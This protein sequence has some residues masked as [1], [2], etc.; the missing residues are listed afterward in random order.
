M[1]P[2]AY[3]GRD[4]TEVCSRFWVDGCRRAPARFGRVVGGKM[5]RT[6][7]R[8][9]T[10]TPAAHVGARLYG[11]VQQA[12][13]VCCYG[14]DG[15]RGVL[16]RFGKVDDGVAA[17]HE[18][19]YGYVRDRCI[20]GYGLRC[21]PAP[22]RR[23]ELAGWVS[24]HPGEGLYRASGSWTSMRGTPS[25]DSDRA[26]LCAHNGM[27]GCPNLAVGDEISELNTFGHLNRFK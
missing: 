23:Y 20:Q 5:R 11:S 16:A 18:G 10:V 4:R 15:R 27:L 12:L 3:A 25:N 19:L 8:C 1:T 21:G 24:G 6:G 14:V 13:I 17:A 9:C 22:R 7:A 2:A 26:R